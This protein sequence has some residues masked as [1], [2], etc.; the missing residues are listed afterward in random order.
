MLKMKKFIIGILFIAFNIIQLNAQTKFINHDL[1]TEIQ[2]ENSFISVNDNITIPNSYL[3]KGF[4]FLLNENFAV[5]N[6]SKDV[7]L[8]IVQKSVKSS[9]LGMD[10]ENEESYKDLLLTKYEIIFPEN[11]KVEKDKSSE[12]TFYVDKSRVNIAYNVI[13]GVSESKN[14][15]SCPVDFA[16]MSFEYIF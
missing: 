4:S 1:V 16:F 7:T 15:G 11:F 6:L 10:R 14:D 8:K 5:E 2:P 3:K 12:I 9:D 13:D